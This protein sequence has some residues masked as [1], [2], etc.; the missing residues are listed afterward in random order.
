MPLRIHAY[1]HAA[2]YFVDSTVPTEWCWF[3]CCCCCCCCWC[4]YNEQILS[5][6]KANTWQQFFFTHQQAIHQAYALPPLSPSLSVCVC[7]A[8]NWSV[9]VYANEIITIHLALSNWVPKSN[10]FRVL[11]YHLCVCVWACDDA[12]WVPLHECPMKKELKRMMKRWE[13]VDDELEMWS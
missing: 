12:V 1:H 8:Q 6:E 10:S 3:C 2:A 11:F 7:I 4:C 5:A 13:I 9:Q